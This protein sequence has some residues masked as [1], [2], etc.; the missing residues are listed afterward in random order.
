MFI[1]ALLTTARTWKQP[2]CPSTEEWI[3]KMC[4]IYTMEYYSA[5]KNNEI[6]PFAATRMGLESVILSEVSQTEKNKFI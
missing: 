5:I 2:K 1:A 3:R 6:M 4:C